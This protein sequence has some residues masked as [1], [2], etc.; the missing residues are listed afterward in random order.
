MLIIK[1]SSWPYSPL[2]I[3][4]YNISIIFWL[5][6]STP[7]K[8]ILV[9]Q[10]G[11]WFPIWKHKKCS[12]PPISIDLSIKYINIQHIHLSVDIFKNLL[13]FHH[14]SLIAGPTF[15]VWCWFARGRPVEKY[16]RCCAVPHA[17]MWHSRSASN[18]G[19]ESWPINKKRSFYT[20]YMGL[21]T[22][23]WSFWMCWHIQQTWE[24][25]R[26]TSI[27]AWCFS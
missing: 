4:I 8:K 20:F 25:H 11:W 2:N 14:P 7:L 26:V 21:K 6:V 27:I 3:F 10:L 19:Y 9:S 22:R 24:S 23:Y 12:K 17:K 15:Q 1:S 13:I 18:A 5:V 16:L